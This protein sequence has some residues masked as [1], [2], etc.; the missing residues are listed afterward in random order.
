[1]S[2]GRVLIV[3]DDI[4]IARLLK[5]S[6]K[7]NNYDFILV[8]KGLDA[9]SAFMNGNFDVVLL[10]LGLPDID[11]LEVLDTI[12][13]QS[14]VPIIVL[15]A[16]GKE[17]DKVMALDQGADD[18]LTKP[19]HIGELFARIRVALRKSIPIESKQNVYEFRDLKVDVEKRKVTIRDLE[20]H[21][22][23]IEYQM[24][25]LLL[26]NQGKVLTHQFIQKKVWGYETM[27]DYQTLRVFMASIRRK[28][29]TDNSYV[30]YIQTEIGVGY[31]FIDE[32]S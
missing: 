21:F 20:I 23:P 5:V 22:T 13:M 30:Q 17:K 32:Q 9:I 12:R 4:V 8:N 16:R 7:T 6:L 27:D 19:F 31:R 15:S 11:G 3:E 29:E 2:N 10:D 18:Y 24:L 28:L 25:I 1:M 14:S 26:E